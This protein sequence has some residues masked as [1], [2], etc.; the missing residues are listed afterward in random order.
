MSELADCFRKFDVSESLVKDFVE[1]TGDSNPIHS[2]SD[3][4]ESTSSP[5]EKVAPGSLLVS[6]FTAIL[7]SEMPG[8]G[9]V[10]LKLSAHFMKPV[11]V[12][13]NI[14]LQVQVTKREK[15][16]HTLRIQG[17]FSDEKGTKLCKVE[18]LVLFKGQDNQKWNS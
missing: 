4:V 9:T 11:V 13:Q 5:L 17:L 12:G 6:L 10:I 15:L 18:S 1:L 8:S 2:V 7:G 3:C 16:T 14:C